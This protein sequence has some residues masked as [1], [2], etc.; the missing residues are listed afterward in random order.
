MPQDRQTPVWWNVNSLV[1]IKNGDIFF[2][3]VILKC[4]KIGKI[5]SEIVI[6]KLAQYALLWIVLHKK[7]LKVH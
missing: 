2:M 5:M 4:I 3:S 7:E 6:K 1:D